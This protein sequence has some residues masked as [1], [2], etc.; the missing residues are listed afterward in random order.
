MFNDHFSIGFDRKSSSAKHHEESTKFQ[1]KFFNDVKKLCKALSQ[2]GNPFKDRSD[3]LINIKTHDV[4]NKD[5]ISSYQNLSSVG[6]SSHKEYVLSVVAGETSIAE[7][8]KKVDL[9]LFSSHHRKGQTK[10]Q[11]ETALMK[12]NLKLAHKLW[13]TASVRGITPEEFFKHE[14]NIDPPSIA[15]AGQMRQSNKSDILSCLEE[16]SPLSKCPV[17]PNTVTAGLIDA[18][19]LVH[20]VTPDLGSSFGDYRTKITNYGKSKLTKVLHE[21]LS[22]I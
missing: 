1:E 5:V 12:Q 8:L 3:E 22:T 9:L 17:T 15:F 19:C 16:V 13:M 7:T 2:H 10:Q 20:M 18:P 11:T 21:P 4:M 6:A 14:N